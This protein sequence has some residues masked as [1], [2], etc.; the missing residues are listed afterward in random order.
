M[1][2]PRDDICATQMNHRDS[3]TQVGICSAHAGNYDNIYRYMYEHDC[4]VY[5]EDRVGSEVTSSLSSRFRVQAS[6]MSGA[7]REKKGFEDREEREW[8]Q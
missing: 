2:I 7:K 5:R 8:R 6:M 1:A 3:K 4:M